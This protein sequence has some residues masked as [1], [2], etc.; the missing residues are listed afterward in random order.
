MG[1]FAVV[2]FTTFILMSYVSLLALLLKVWHRQT[3]N[4]IVGKEA[5][6]SVTIIIPTRNEE[7]SI[8]SCLTL[9]F[10]NKFPEHLL[11]VIVVDDHSSDDTRLLVEKKFSG[12]LTCLSLPEGV[13]GKKQAI[14]LGVEYAQND[15]ILLTDADTQAGPLWIQSHV[16]E[17]SH[18]GIYAVTGSVFPMSGDTVM[19]RFQ[20]LD[21]LSVMAATAFGFRYSL[22]WLANGANMSFRKEIFKNVSGYYGNEHMASGDDVFLFKKIRKASPNSI[23]FVHHEDI[24]V[25]T[26]FETTWTGFLQ[27]RKRWAT[28]TVAYANNTLFTFQG[29]VCIA[30]VY[31][32]LMMVLS[33]FGGA[34][35]L[36]TGLL[37]LCIKL[38][39]DFYFLKKM[40]T[41]IHCSGAMKNFLISTFL[42]AIYMFCAFWWTFFPSPYHWKSRRVN[43]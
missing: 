25:K 42:H 31:P 29:I 32:F 22:F 34:K 21:Y 17:Y 26:A 5:G 19:G 27:Q 8:V 6:C 9:I 24:M 1:L 12:K 16:S 41:S 14:T 11:Q 18:P 3:R 7:Q 36:L 43:S 2:T 39:A 20:F 4:N 13:F 30:V 28:K 15:I 40:E 37:F 35:L 33:A 38:V 23:V 10:S